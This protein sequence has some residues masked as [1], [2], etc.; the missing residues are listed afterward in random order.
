MSRV[1]G[2]AK[3]RDARPG[4]R[5]EAARAAAGRQWGRGAVLVAAAGLIALVA[6][7]VSRDQGGAPRSESAGIRFR[8][9][10]GREGSLADFDGRPLVLNF[11]ASWCPTC[12]G[13]MADFQRVYLKEKERVGFL[14]LALQETEQGARAIMKRTGVTY[15]LGSDPTGEIFST[16]GGLGMPTTVF[17]D[18]RGRV[19]EQITGGLDEAALFRLIRR[20]FVEKK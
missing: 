17:F 20:L 7:L 12:W 9:L 5:R 8:Y 15:P 2:D 10:D 1:T 19:V 11:F 16:L 13:E 18:Q 14:G 4:K 6:V 3:R